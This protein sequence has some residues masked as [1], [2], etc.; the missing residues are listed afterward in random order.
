MFYCC[1][2]YISLKLQ[3]VECLNVY[4]SSTLIFNL[5]RRKNFELYLREQVY[6]MSKIYL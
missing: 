5:V 2:G 3:D 6:F 4:S 1:K